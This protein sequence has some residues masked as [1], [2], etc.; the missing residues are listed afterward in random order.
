MIMLGSVKKFGI[1]YSVLQ[2]YKLNGIII[3]GVY[4]KNN[5]DIFYRPIF[6]G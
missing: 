3:K 5:G 6:I 4:E 1:G 2:F